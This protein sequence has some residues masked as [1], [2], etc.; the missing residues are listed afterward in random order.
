VGRLL[1]VEGVGLPPR[2]PVATTDFPAFPPLFRPLAA[3]C[4]LSFSGFPAC[5]CAAALA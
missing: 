1:E 2:L 5:R 3:H 4:N